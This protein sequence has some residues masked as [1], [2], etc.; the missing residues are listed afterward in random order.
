MLKTVSIQSK[1][2]N[3]GNIAKN[4]T[5]IADLQE[6]NQLSSQNIALGKVL[7]VAKNEV[8]INTAQAS[9]DSFKKKGNTAAVST[10]QESIITLKR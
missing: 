4:L 8:A 2:D 3:L 6:W 5:P 1:G 7:I 10:K 9:V